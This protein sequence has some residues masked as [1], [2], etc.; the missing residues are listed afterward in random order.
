[1]EAG[2]IEPPSRDVSERASTC[3][4]DLLNLRMKTPI[5]R[6]WQPLARPFSHPTGA[7]Q[8]GQASPLS[9][10]N[11]T[12][13]RRRLNELLFKQPYATDK[14]WYLSFLPDD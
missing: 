3:I 8:P 14:S 7:E 6:I 5:D 2:G 1:M 10:L 13:G 11:T 12:S 4:V 9:S